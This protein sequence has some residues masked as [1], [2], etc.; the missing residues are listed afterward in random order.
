MSLIGT[1]QTSHTQLRGYLNFAYLCFRRKE[2]SLGKCEWGEGELLV[3]VC[4]GE[5]LSGLFLEL[6]EKLYVNG[7]VLF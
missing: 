1:A 2:A 4:P 7:N 5:M 3:E 6:L